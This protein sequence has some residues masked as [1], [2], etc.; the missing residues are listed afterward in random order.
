MNAPEDQFTL[1]VRRGSAEE[2][3]EN[4]SLKKGKSTRNV[5]DVV[6]KESKLVRV[7]EKEST[8]SP[9]EKMPNPGV[10]PLAVAKAETT[11]LAKI[12]AAEIVGSAAERKGLL[13][14]EVADDVTMVCCP[15]L[16]ALYPGR[17]ILTWM[18]SN[19]SRLAMIA[20]CENMKDRFAI[21]DCP[22]GLNPQQIKDWRMNIAGYDTK[23][24]AVY[25]PWIKI[26]D[27]LGGPSIMT[28]PSGY[29]AGI[30][31][32]SDN[33]RGV[34]KAPANEVVRGAIG[35]EMQITKASRIS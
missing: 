11:A 30:Y 20:H 21:L 26:A 35:L 2:K 9:L 16:M 33:E 6:N 3:F 8:L 31:A 25:Y 4:L 12:S 27:P 13:G 15:D 1:L 28:P 17:A 7:A 14:L 19:P 10:Y 32:R 29:M 18:M 23:Y 5:M 34:H 22:P 24:G